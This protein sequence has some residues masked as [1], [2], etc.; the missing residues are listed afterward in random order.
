LA[1]CCCEPL[2]YGRE[3]K[4]GL[5]GSQPLKSFGMAFMGCRDRAKVSWQDVEVVIE[6]EKE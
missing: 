5:G 4:K 3:I 6:I 2:H 1:V